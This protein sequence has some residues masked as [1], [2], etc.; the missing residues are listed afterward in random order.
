MIRPQIQHLTDDHI[1]GLD[2][3][4]QLCKVV[5]DPRDFNP[6]RFLVATVNGKVVGCVAYWID[7]QPLAWADYLY[8]HPDYQSKGI[9][10]WL[11]L[12]L[13]KILVDHGVKWVRCT[14]TGKLVGMFLRSG[15]EWRTDSVCFE[16]SLEDAKS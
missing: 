2:E 11:A 8:V 14:P 4:F 13:Q 16:R 6:E 12:E 1:P 3:L 10:T 9:G 15:F 5:G 7:G